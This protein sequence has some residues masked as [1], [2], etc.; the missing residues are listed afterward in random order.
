MPCEAVRELV[1]TAFSVR[2]GR[3]RRTFEPGAPVAE[4]SHEGAAPQLND[5]YLYELP[6][7][8]SLHTSL[9]ADSRDA[10]P[11]AAEPAATV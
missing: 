10:E 8:V 11:A 6:D 1:L 5:F 7:S 4:N 2:L 9:T 3:E